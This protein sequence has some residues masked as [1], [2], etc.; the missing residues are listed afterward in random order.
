M[1]I[2]EGRAD[3][4]SVPARGRV[5]TVLEGLDARRCRFA[6]GV[7]WFRVEEEGRDKAI[8]S[9]PVSLDG[10]RER[11]G[12]ISTIVGGYLLQFPV[13]LTKNLFSFRFPCLASSE[14]YKLPE[15]CRWADGCRN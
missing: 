10:C 12:C 3:K 4:R 5:V 8:S 13:S 6:R 11:L 2:S 7:D 1:R 15:Y 9:P 14:P